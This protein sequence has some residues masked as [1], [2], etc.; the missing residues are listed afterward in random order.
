MQTTIC[1][2][3]LAMCFHAYM[4]GLWWLHIATMVAILAIAGI[5][6]A[7]RRMES[8]FVFVLAAVSLIPLNISLITKTVEFTIGVAFYPAIQFCWNVILFAVFFNVEEILLLIISRIIWHCQK[9]I[10][11]G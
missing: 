3:P 4:H 8:I 9:R 5:L 2:I 6:P 11:G 7:A 10:L 1:L